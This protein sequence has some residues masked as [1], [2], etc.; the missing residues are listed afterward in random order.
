MI[1]RKTACLT[2]IRNVLKGV[3]SAPIHTESAWLNEFNHFSLWEKTRAPVVGR[4]RVDMMMMMMAIALLDGELQ[5]DHQSEGQVFMSVS[6]L[7]HLQTGIQQCFL[8]AL[9]A[10]R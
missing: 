9:G 3:W 7:W 2:F 8:G 6:L 5:S 4:N 10:W 1:V